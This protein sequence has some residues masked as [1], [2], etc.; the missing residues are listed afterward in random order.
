MVSGDYIDYSLRFH[1]QPNE[2][3]EFR[4]YLVQSSNI[5]RPWL[6]DYSFFKYQNTQYLL[7]FLLIE[8]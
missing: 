3:V 5:Q 8:F 6:I 1:D 2:F 7:L 4:P